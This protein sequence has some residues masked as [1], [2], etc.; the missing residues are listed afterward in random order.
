MDDLTLRF[1]DD[2]EEFSTTVLIGG[3][4]FDDRSLDPS[5]FPRLFQC[6]DELPEIAVVDHDKLL[7]LHRLQ[8]RG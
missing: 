2:S 7:P 5:Q 4:F 3:G 6:G 8:F 1:D